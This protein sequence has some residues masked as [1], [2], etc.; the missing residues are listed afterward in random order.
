[1]QRDGSQGREI[2]MKIGTGLGIGGKGDP[3][4]D[5]RRIA[6]MERAG[7]DFV[8]VGEAWGFDA[9]TRLA[10]IAAKTERIQLATNIINVFSRSPSTIA[11]TA[12]AWTSCRAAVSCWAR[13]ARAARSS[14]DSTGCPSSSHCRALST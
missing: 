9:V 7:L 3:Q 4:E 12:R 5:V 11:A 6:D 13:A 1:M 8:S 14:R 10:Y 2:A